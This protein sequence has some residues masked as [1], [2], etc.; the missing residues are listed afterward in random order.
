MSG[1]IN[2]ANSGMQSKQQNLSQVSTHII[3]NIIE[4]FDDNEGQSRTK[5]YDDTY[6]NVGAG[7][8]VITNKY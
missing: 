5:I 2:D 6:V 8:N 1:I 7:K 4:Q 3:I